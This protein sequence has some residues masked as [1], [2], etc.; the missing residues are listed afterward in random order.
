MADAGVLVELWQ[1]GGGWLVCAGIS[2]LIIQRLS[3]AIVA[4][5]NAKATF[6][7]RMTEAVDKV[8]LWPDQFN[9]SM[10]DL[11][12][13]VKELKQRTEDHTDAIDHLTTVLNITPRRSR[14]KAKE[15]IND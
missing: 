8:L 15:G 11:K 14:S 13:E 9:V 5:I 10:H 12:T 1:G 2:W 6:S 3:P 7:R 4:Y